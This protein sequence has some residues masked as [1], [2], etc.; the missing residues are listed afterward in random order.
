M[1]YGRQE[2]QRKISICDLRDIHWSHPYYPIEMITFGSVEEPLMTWSSGWNWWCF[3][4]QSTLGDKRNVLYSEVHGN[5]ICMYNIHLNK[6]D[7]NYLKMTQ[8]WELQLI[9][10]EFPL[11]NKTLGTAEDGNVLD[12][13]MARDEN[14]D[15]RKHDQSRSAHYSYSF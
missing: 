6:I 8:R 7:L 9:L 13:P 12:R 5:Y 4:I 3:L 11:E 10:N 15:T 1:S 2:V 14:A